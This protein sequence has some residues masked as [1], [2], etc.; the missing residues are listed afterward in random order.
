MEAESQ[1]FFVSLHLLQV[2]HRTSEKTQ[3]DTDRLTATAQQGTLAWLTLAMNVTAVKVASFTPIHSEK[4]TSHT[5][6]KS[7]ASVAV[8][9]RGTGRR[10][11]QISGLLALLLARKP[12]WE[13][14][15]KSLLT[16]VNSQDRQQEVYDLST[17]VMACQSESTV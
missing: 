8:L 6:S 10:I 7:Y 1:A 9:F 16:T 5:S 11:A 14:L 15:N 12:V 17:Q 13:L 4:W 3:G 2:T